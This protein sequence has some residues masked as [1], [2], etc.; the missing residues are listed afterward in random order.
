MVPGPTDVAAIALAFILPA[1]AM[2]LLMPGYARFLVARGRTTGDS[3]KPGGVV[4]PTPAGPLIMASLMVG[5]VAAWAF[6]RSPV[7]LVLIV[8]VA[9]V[10]LIGLYDDLR[11]LG[12]VVK[13]ALLA[14]VGLFVAVAEHLHRGVYSPVLYFPLF[15]ETGTHY[16]IF[17]LI[18]VASVPVSANAFNMLDAFNGEISGFTAIVSAALVVAVVL[19]AYALPGTSLG[20][21]AMA[22][23]LLA[24][25]ASFYY[26][27]RYPSRIFDGDSGSLSFGAMYVILSIVGGVEIA[28]LVALIPAVVNSYYILS[29][30]RGL[31]ERKRMAARPTFLGDDMKLHASS[32]AKAPTT[33]VRMILLG[34]PL[35][36]RALVNRILAITAYA[37]FLSVVTS[38][39]TWL[40]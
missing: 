1:A 28:A 14:G 36:E 38:V 23:P 6:F 35:D 10:G 7:P 24:T 9:S 18:V 13:P 39:M 25:S 26:F 5:E 8:V 19:R 22:V 20:T 17:A 34:G 3:H 16:I 12:G 30:V 37:A 2:L 21:V 15:T 29:S 11:G 4:V 40:L 31:V 27:N 33:L 32:D